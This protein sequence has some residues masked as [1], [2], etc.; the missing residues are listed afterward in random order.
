MN[1]PSI[2]VVDDEPDNFDVID[3]LLANCGYELRYA[4]DG[5]QA[6]ESLDIIK[7]DLILLDVMMPE[8]DG[9]HVCKL[10]N[11]HPQ[12]QFIPIII[13][14]ALHGKED[15]AR[16][17]EAGA[18]DFVSKPVNRLELRARIESMLRIKRQRD[19]IQQAK[20]VAE[21]A[22]QA[23]STFL[24]MMSH[25]IRTPIHGVLGMTQLLAATELTP[26]QQKY[27]N[28]AQ[29]SGQMLL[30]TIED[31]LDFSK[32]ESGKL[33]LEERPLDLPL[34]LQ[35]ICDLLL[36][37]A[38]E[39]Q[40]ELSYHLADNIPNYII[41][42]I[43]RLRQILLNLVNNAVKFTA[44]G[45]IK[46]DCQTKTAGS[47][48]YELHFAIA[49]TGI[50]IAAADLDRLFQPFTQASN[51]TT[52]EY[53][54]TGL[55]LTI[56]RHLIEM[57][58]GR[59]WVE[60]ELGCG[61]TFHLTI[62]VA[63]TDRLPDRTL[64]RSSENVTPLGSQLPLSILVA[65]DNQISRELALAMFA[66]LGYQPDVVQDGLAVIE[67]VQLK[68]YDIVFLDW[69][70]PKLDGLAVAK[71][72][73]DWD[74]LGL[75][76]DRPKVIAMTANALPA[77]RDRCLA[78]GMD[79]YISKP[80][81]LNTLERV[82]HKWGEPITGLLE[83]IATAPPPQS[84]DLKAIE[85]LSL[86]SPTLIHRVIP[87]FLD[88]EVPKSIA[89]FDKSLQLGEFTEI[90][91]VAHSLRGTSAALGATELA[92]LCQQL[93]STAQTGDFN[94]IECEIAAIKIECAAVRHQ[95]LNALESN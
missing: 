53:G 56:C 15:L 92:R 17:L 95:L 1:L 14:T 12:W 72:L 75:T 77:D 45:S 73:A 42:D 81:F 62:T 28:T 93:E 65:E 91:T 44:S 86:I 88:D 46:I 41:S 54:G 23:K 8:I 38:T 39:K 59:I 94:C 48:R 66:Q 24:A 7:P 37:K 67:A 51:T 19:E 74:K 36:P 9:L 31:I 71:W 26:T 80:I 22:T 60:S 70:M 21:L 35:D 4:A 29:V 20:A 84:L 76:F 43:T 78:A 40:L 83:A 55:G 68:N 52:R 6:I 30:A 89:Q 16:C 10:M 90:G 25:E 47:D 87:L 63:A 69:Q 79:D 2:L 49:D 33:T 32:I 27:V 34:L 85:R 11:A 50:G 13:V 82:L 3:A 64:A 18:N 5:K 61:T 57:M 58:Q